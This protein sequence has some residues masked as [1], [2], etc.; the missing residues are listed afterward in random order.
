MISTRSH[1]S[2][3]RASALLIA[4]WALTV[5]SFA[6]LGMAKIVS[7]RLDEDMSHNREAEAINLAQC[8]LA[9]AMHPNVRP[10]E[11]ILQKEMEPGSSFIATLTSEESRLQ[12][13]AI[14]ADS[15]KRPILE[16]LFYFW[17]L[18]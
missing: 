8:G 12:I 16:K 15:K 10:G 3:V 7:A 9:L 5:L 1:S 14:L 13:N 17:G 4:L 11:S 2:P 18:N 6:I